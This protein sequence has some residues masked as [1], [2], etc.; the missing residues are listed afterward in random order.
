[1]ARAGF[2]PREAAKIWRLIVKE[3]TADPHRRMRVP[4]LESHPAEE[5]RIAALEKDAAT[6]LTPQLE[7]V[8]GKAEFDAMVT[9]LRALML[10][11][12][13]TMR[14]PERTEVVLAQLHA[15]G[16]LNDA[17]FAY[18]RGEMIRLRGGTGDA[19]RALA[20]YRAAIA[21][22]GVPPVGLRNFGFLLR[23]AGDAEG[24]RIAFARYLDL[25][26]DAPDR[27]VIEGHIQELTP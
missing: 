2:D 3:D 25:L 17:E 1:M 5:V 14:R 4:F 24:A 22:D 10:A 13:L 19:E 12:E 20:L 15:E 7:G 11:D 8:T 27:A 9:P 21:G 6:Q 18:Q 16:R 26:P 23:N